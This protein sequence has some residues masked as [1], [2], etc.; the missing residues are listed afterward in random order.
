MGTYIAHC[1]G[2]VSTVTGDPLADDFDG[3]EA[4]W[5]WC[6]ERLMVAYEGTLTMAR[7]SDPEGGVT[8]R[9]WSIEPQGSLWRTLMEI[10][11]D[12]LILWCP[13]HQGEDGGA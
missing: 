9:G 13:R 10:E 8:A 4:E 5:T 1:A 7:L 11:H 12:R 3:P 2:T 6:P